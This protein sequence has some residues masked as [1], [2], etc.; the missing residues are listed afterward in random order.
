MK[1]SNPHGG[2]N[3]DTSGRRRSQ[4]DNP[5]GRAYPLAHVQ[6]GPVVGWHQA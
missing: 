6:V 5:S 4:T 3:R 2:L 1:A